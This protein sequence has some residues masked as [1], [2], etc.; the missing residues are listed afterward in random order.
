MG[1]IRR[2]VTAI[3]TLQTHSDTKWIV[4]GDFSQQIGDERS[5]GVS[6]SGRRQPTPKLAAIV[7]HF[8]RQIA[9]VILPTGKFQ[10]RLNL[11]IAQT[12]HLRFLVH[13]RAKANFQVSEW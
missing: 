5:I 6:G 4:N 12:Q 3:F 1:N 13:L 11:H 2:N 8:H 7:V 10:M 9:V